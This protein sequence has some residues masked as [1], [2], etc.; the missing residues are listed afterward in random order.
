MFR[1]D[2]CGY[3]TE[4]KFCLHRHYSRKN[5]CPATM[6]QVAIVALVERDFPATTTEFMCEKC[7]NCFASAQSKWNH[8]QRC[9]VGSAHTEC[10]VPFGQEQIDVDCDEFKAILLEYMKLAAEPIDLGLYI[11]YKFFNSAHPENQT[12]RKQRRA[13]T[14]IEYYDGHTWRYDSFQAV[15]EKIMRLFEQE[16]I[17]MFNGF[18]GRDRYLRRDGERYMFSFRFMMNV[19]F[20]FRFTELAALIDECSDDLD[21]DVAS[22]R[23]FRDGTVELIPTVIYKFT[24]EL[25]QNNRSIGA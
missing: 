8:T 18:P 14:H 7:G 3:T 19:G 13:D 5:P 10:L 20:P 17:A 6:S 25:Q 1:C 24:K 21:Y 9:K 23:E 15:A 22:Q 12:L 4:S 2:R 16:I 11:K